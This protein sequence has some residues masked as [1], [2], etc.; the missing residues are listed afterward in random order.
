MIIPIP[1]GVYASQNVVDAEENPFS[2]QSTGW[3]KIRAIS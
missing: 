3:T 1:R 2:S